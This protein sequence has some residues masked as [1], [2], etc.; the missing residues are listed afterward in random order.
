[1][2]PGATSNSTRLFPLSSAFYFASAFPLA[3]AKKKKRKDEQSNSS[4][5][6]QSANMLRPKPQKRLNIL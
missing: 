3:L 4:P 5:W 2:H 1:M 6:P